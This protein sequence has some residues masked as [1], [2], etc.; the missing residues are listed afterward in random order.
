MTGIDLNKNL[1]Y[2]IASFRYFEKKEHHI[3]RFCRHNVL[4]LVLDGVLRF[5]ED[6]EEA[7]VRAGEYYVQ[8]KDRYQ[9]GETA[10][11]APKY[12]YVH[13]DGEW[14]DDE[15]AFP[16][17]GKF[18]V[19]GLYALMERID[20]AAH[21]ERTQAEL[22]YLFL[23]LILTLKEKAVTSDTASRLFDYVEKKLSRISSLSDMCEEFH[24]SK[25]YIIRIFKKEL[26][27]SP[28]KYINAMRIKRAK[29]LLGST[30]KS[31]R[32]IAEECGYSDYPYFYKCFVRES[33][34]SPLRWRKQIQEDPLYR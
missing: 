8:R 9:S 19:E 7:E 27:T 4:L 1:T 32:E 29:Y 31:V 18:D 23:K 12:L 10:S 2:K 5:S 13:F 3:S 21:A 25:N 11:D 28:I 6:G 34:L 33:G 30:S 26:G 22:Q 14:C 16:Y 24:Y 15:N 20:S 17:R